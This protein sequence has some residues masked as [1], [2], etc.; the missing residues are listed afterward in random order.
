M[1]HINEDYAAS[2]ATAKSRL[3][4]RVTKDKIESQSMA[5]Q[6]SLMPLSMMPVCENNNKE[7]GM[8]R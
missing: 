1:E 6:S 4:N 2:S 5:V 8:N 3:F 7:P